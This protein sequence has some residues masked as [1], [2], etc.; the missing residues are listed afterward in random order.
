MRI[1][2][3][4]PAERTS[5]RPR[6]P[7][8]ALTLLAV[9]RRILPILVSLA[10]AVPDRAAALRRLRRSRPTARST[11]WSRAGSYPLAPDATRALPVLGAQR[12]QHARLAA[13]QGRR[14]ELLGLVVRTL[15]DRGAAARARPDAAS[16]GTTR[17]CSASPTSTPRPTPKASSAATTSP[18]PICATPPANSRT[19]T[20]RD[21]LP[22][23]FI[24]N[25]QGRIVAISRGE[26]EQAFV[27]QALALAESS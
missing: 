5:H 16:N 14:A 11:S 2:A 27:N 1:V 18:T 9:R 24:I 7:A 26:I 4:V 6:H 13:G 8:A 19:P 25:R 12:Q 22:E 17:R 21:Q 10:G 20:A 3:S 15:P 23:S